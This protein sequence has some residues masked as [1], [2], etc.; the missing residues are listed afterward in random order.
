VLLDLDLRTREDIGDGGVGSLCKE[1]VDG[2]FAFP[3][4]CEARV[5]RYSGRIKR[6]L[7][8]LSPGFCPECVYDLEREEQF[9]RRF[10]FLQR[11]YYVFVPE[12]GIARYRGWPS[13]GIEQRPP[14]RHVNL[15]D[16][17]DIEVCKWDLHGGLRGG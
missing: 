3:R 7:D 1:K 9:G 14:H 13:Y 10:V 6:P 16:C 12:F 17:G 11:G 5:N 4:G 15:F 8:C 2:K